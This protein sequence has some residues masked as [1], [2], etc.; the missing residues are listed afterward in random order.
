MSKSGNLWKPMLCMTLLGVLL[1]SAAYAD[2]ALVVGVQRYANLPPQANQLKGCVND[3]KAIAKALEKYGFQVT[4]LLNEQATKQGILDALRKEQAAIKPAERFVFYFA[5]HGTDA[6]RHSLLP[7]DARDDVASNHINKDELYAAVS[8]VPAYSRTVL[9][10]S[11]FS[12]GM[13]NLFKE[14][15]P[16]L[17]ARYYPCRIGGGGARSPVPV[18]RQ[19]TNEHLMGSGGDVCYYTAA[20]GNEK[21]LE[22]DFNGVQHGVFTHFLASRLTG[23]KDLWGDIHTVVKSRVTSF[24]FDWQHPTLWPAPY[25]QTPIFEG[26]EAKPP[27]APLA[28]PSTLRDIYNSDYV[29]PGQVSLTMAPNKTSLAVEEPLTLTATV[30]SEG[31]LVILER[32]VDNRVYLLFPKS[33]NVEDARV[34]PGQAFSKRYAGDVA[35]TEHVKAVLYTSREKAAALLATMPEGDDGVPFVGMGSRRLRELPPN[36]APF[37]TSAITFEIVEAAPKVKP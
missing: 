6:P 30:G 31:Y 26:K 32:F 19:D 28:E 33:R 16:N 36:S 12:G 9:L 29:D 18:N 7:H 35:G 2:R 8:A 15:R 13:R 24:V 20:M 10:D 3:A 25:M 22:D 21:A 4:M 23:R 17:R 11:C 1:P 5:G 37:F 27:A 34:K 14:G